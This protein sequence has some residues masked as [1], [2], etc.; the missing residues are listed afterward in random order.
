ME[1]DGILRNACTIVLHGLEEWKK[2]NKGV[3]FKPGEGLVGRV[4]EMKSSEGLVEQQLLCSLKFKRAVLANSCGVRT[5]VGVNARLNELNHRF[6]GIRGVVAFFSRDSIMMGK[7]L[8]EIVESYVV[9]WHEHYQHSKLK[10][11]KYQKKSLYSLAVEKLLPDHCKPVK[12]RD[13]YQ[14]SSDPIVCSTL[15]KLDTPP[16]SSENNTV[17]LRS[18]LPGKFKPAVGDKVDG[19]RSDNYNDTKRHS[20]SNPAVSLMARSM[21]DRLPRTYPQPR[22]RHVQMQNSYSGSYGKS[23]RFSSFIQ[24]PQ[25]RSNNS[26]TSSRP[27]TGLHSM[28]GSSIPQQHQPRN[29]VFDVHHASSNPHQADSKS[30]YVNK[31]SIYAY[32]NPTLHSFSGAN[33]TLPIYRST[34]SHLAARYKES[35]FPASSRSNLSN[36]EDSVGFKRKSESLSI[37]SNLPYEA[38]KKFKQDIGG[39]IPRRA[40]FAKGLQIM[41]ARGRSQAPQQ[42]HRHR[43]QYCG[44][45]FPKKGNWRAHL[46]V[47]TQEKP[48]ACEVCG[49]KFSQKS[50]MKRHAKMHTR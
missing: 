34:G 39:G 45:T 40:D 37:S 6:I 3:T 47:H 35:S 19:S 14:L 22:P 7:E 30:L 12:F 24:N 20:S 46:R 8:F 48:F 15:F 41:L 44:K 38:V 4:C 18:T 33:S 16:S 10:D 17:D 13:G 21:P 49:K 28:S 26:N 50:N 2:G 32:K 5:V 42:H 43:C 29:P 27:N 1:D 11:D 36:H 31:N 23:T 25:I 9:K